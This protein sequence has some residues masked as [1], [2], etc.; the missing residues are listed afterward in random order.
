MV[1]YWPFRLSLAEY[2]EGK[3]SVVEKLKTAGVDA[4]QIAIFAASPKDKK[5]WAINQYRPNGGTLGYHSVKN[6]QTGQVYEAGLS[7]LM[8]W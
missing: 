4:M 2:N 6:K 3:E 1:T 8:V 5:V 7:N